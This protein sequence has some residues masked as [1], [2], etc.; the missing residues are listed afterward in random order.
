MVVHDDGVISRKEG[1]NVSH[2]AV[3]VAPGTICNV[4]RTRCA[5]KRRRPARRATILMWVQGTV[6][7]DELA[8]LREARNPPQ[9]STRKFQACHYIRTVIVRALIMV[10]LC[11]NSQEPCQVTLDHLFLRRMDTI[12]LGPR[13]VNGRPQLAHA[14]S[15]LIR[16]Q[17]PG[18]WT[19]PN[20][21]VKWR[22]C[23]ATALARISKRC[24]GLGWMG[25]VDDGAAHMK[26]THSPMGLHLADP[27][28]LM[29]ARNHSSRVWHLWGTDGYGYVWIR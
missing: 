14:S 10:R 28:R 27:V 11:W 8:G 1:R 5:A 16:G 18:K 6:C 4:A 12:R 29:K 13:T 15:S 20:R 17:T 22:P 23:D 19:A 2:T 7:Q 26:Y 25:K 21:T 3:H 24:S 9:T